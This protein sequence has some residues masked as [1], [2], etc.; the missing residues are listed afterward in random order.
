[1]NHALALS[2]TVSSL[3]TLIGLCVALPTAGL[4]ARREGIWRHLIEAGLLAPLVMPPTVLGYYLLALLGRRSFLG[5]HYEQVFGEPIVFSAKG[6][7]L[8]ALIGVT[9][10]ILRATTAGIEAIDPIYAETAQTLG[11]SRFRAYCTIL[12]PMAKRSIAAG[13]GLGFARSLGDFGLTLMLAGNIPGRTQTASLY[14][15]DR[16]LAGDDMTAGRSAALLA[17]AAIA[18]LVGVSLLGQREK[19]TVRASAP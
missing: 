18:I 9:P 10:M 13:A 5:T 6:A 2:L 19:K 7:I 15:Y 4:L 1:V 12:I 16:M 11:A 8:A 14:I 3:A 17:F